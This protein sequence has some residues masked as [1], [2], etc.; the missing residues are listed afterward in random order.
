MQAAFPEPLERAPG[1][2]LQN[3]HS[4]GNKKTAEILHFANGKHCHTS[5]YFNNMRINYFPTASQLL[6]IATL[7]LNY[8]IITTF[9]NFSL[10]WLGVVLIRKQQYSSVREGDTSAN[11]STTSLNSL[12]PR[13]ISTPISFATRVVPSG[14]SQRFNKAQLN[15]VD[16]TAARLEPSRNVDYLSHDWVEEDIWSSW[17]YIVSRRRHFGQCSREE[18]ASWRVWA[19]QKYKLKTVNPNTINWYVTTHCNA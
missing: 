9:T 3:F 13:I 15:S 10:H 11:S 2:G 7:L 4:Q 14:S 18:N 16:D 6:S 12:A 8:Q 1:Q 17:R 19:K 5:G